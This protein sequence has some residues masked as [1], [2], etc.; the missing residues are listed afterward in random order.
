MYLWR[1]SNHVDLSGRGGLLASGRW[2]KTGH[3]IVYCADHPS[4]ALLE[5]LV[6]MDLED[7]PSH[8]KLLKIA[9]PDGLPSMRIGDNDVDTAD[10]AATQALG[11]SL[12]EAGN[13]CLIEVPSVVMP[14]AR[15]VLINPKHPAAGGIAIET[16]FDYP[17]DS[18]LLR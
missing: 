13:A 15:N 7:L 4:T 12:L 6:H 1:I 2:H 17:F 5:I 11:T 9:C 18:R 14:Q 10:L 16:T 8:Y 3:P